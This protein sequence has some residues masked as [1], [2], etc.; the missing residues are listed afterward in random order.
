M[1]QILFRII[2]T[3]LLLTTVTNAQMFYEYVGATETELTN[4]FG[5]GTVQYG[6]IK[7]IS[8]IDPSNDTMKLYKIKNKK[9]FEALNV[10]AC[11][12]KTSAR[13]YYYA[14]IKFLVSEGFSQDD[15]GYTK[16]RLSRGRIRITIDYAYD[17]ESRI[18]RVQ[19][20]AR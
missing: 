2:V 13:Q 17:A 11:N 1:E 7:T 19:E 16:S 18:W 15:I 8:Y 3:L 9:I 10:L 14:M 4:A 6:T 20:R 5:Y 12:S